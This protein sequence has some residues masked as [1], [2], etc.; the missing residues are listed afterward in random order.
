M[1]LQYFQK[2]EK[3]DID[4]QERAQTGKHD[5]HA[6]SLCINLPALFTRELNQT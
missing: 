4:K 2:S 5:Q 1:Y 6:P 3:Q